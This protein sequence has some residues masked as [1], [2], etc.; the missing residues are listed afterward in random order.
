MKA[1]LVLCLFI[2]SLVS[3]SLHASE[4]GDCQITPK[5][6]PSGIDFYGQFSYGDTL[7]ESLCQL[8]EF[9]EEKYTELAFSRGAWYGLNIDFGAESVSSSDWTGLLKDIFDEEDILN[10]P[11]AGSLMDTKKRDSLQLASFG[12]NQDHPHAATIF[13]ADRIRLNVEPILLAGVE[14]N[15]TLGF[16]PNLGLLFEED[17]RFRN[18]VMSVSFARP[19]NFCNTSDAPM[20]GAVD[21]RVTA[22]LPHIL[23]SVE[24]SSNSPNL[25]LVKESIIE[26]I[27]EK[28]GEYEYTFEEKG[29]SDYYSFFDG[30][31]R[32]VIADKRDGLS[33]TYSMD[34]S[35][36]RSA[37]NKISSRFEKVKQAANNQFVKQAADSGLNDL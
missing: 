11:M 7:L 15:A 4:S 6:Y 27:V 23:Q 29:H 24:L 31:V 22:Y 20:C 14:F 10:N 12:L 30:F 1:F 21:D 35:S 26:R 34:A 28:Y 16:E 25:S 2:S 36:D 33:I 8:N 5:D 18:E 9:S 3:G 32:L 37:F 19:N 13:L 17:G